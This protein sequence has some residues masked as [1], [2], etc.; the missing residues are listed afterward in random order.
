[1]FF[2]FF[3]RNNNKHSPGLSDPSLSMS[4]RLFFSRMKEKESQTSLFCL[5]RQWFGND[6]PEKR[7]EQIEWTRKKQQTHTQKRSESA[8]EKRKTKESNNQN[9]QLQPEKTHSRRSRSRS[10]SRNRNHTNTSYYHWHWSSE[11]KREREG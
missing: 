1:M 10:R 6:K 2:V 4:S 11:R 9:F 7:I 8:G 3:S 5:L